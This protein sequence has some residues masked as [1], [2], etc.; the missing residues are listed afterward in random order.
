M[1]AGYIAVWLAG[2][3]IYFLIVARI[4]L[5]DL[6]VAP[7]I[8]MVAA[9]I[10]GGEVVRKPGKALSPKRWLYGLAYTV[11]Y[12]LVVE[13][14]CHLRVAS[15]VLGLRD[16]MPDIVEVPFDYRTDYAVAATA[17]SITNTPGTIVV[18]IDPEAKKYLVH[19]L[20]AYT[21]D[22][23]IVREKIIMVFDKWIKKI[24]ED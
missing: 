9:L 6:V 19:W 7:I 3:L 20:E 15:M 23:R 13:P 1:R 4:T 24:F 17:N 10:V 2:I 22:P 8:S 18:D 14:A 16:Y 12:L 21:R 11:Y 5:F